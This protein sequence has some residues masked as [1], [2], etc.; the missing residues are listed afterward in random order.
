MDLGVM[1]LG[2]V[3]ARGTFN[4]TG[5]VGIPIRIGGMEFAPGRFAYCDLDG[6]VVSSRPLWPVE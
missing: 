4:G 3:P 5:E 6:I 2:T 1:A